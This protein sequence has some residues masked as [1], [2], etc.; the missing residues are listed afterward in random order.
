MKSFDFTAEVKRMEALAEEAE[1]RA[2]ATG[3]M[4]WFDE[5]DYYKGL[6]EKLRDLAWH[7][8]CL[9]NDGILK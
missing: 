2:E 8:D 3:L 5:V 7:Y 9:E 6:A 4:K 1:A